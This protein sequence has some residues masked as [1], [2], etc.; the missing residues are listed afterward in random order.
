MQTLAPTWNLSETATTKWY[1]RLFPSLN[2]IAFLLPV[3][4]LFAKMNGTQMLFSDGDTGWHIR[5]GEW[6][7]AHRMVPTTDL[8]SFTK[9]NEAWFAWEWA[10]DLIFAGIIVWPD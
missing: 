4:V 7:A 1:G 6:I 3:V 10:W 9:P 5:T 2:D 8:F